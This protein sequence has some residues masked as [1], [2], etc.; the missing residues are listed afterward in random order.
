MDLTTHCAMC[1]ARHPDSEPFLWV[2][3]RDWCGDADEA[4]ELE[5]RDDHVDLMCGCTGRSKYHSVTKSDD[6]LNSVGSYDTV[7]SGH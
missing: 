5:E 7:A 3:R 1:G 2:P 4:I 6:G